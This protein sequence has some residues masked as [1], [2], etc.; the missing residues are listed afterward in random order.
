MKVKIGEKEW[1]R[2]KVKSQFKDELGCGD[3]ECI[4][5]VNLSCENCKFYDDIDV[6]VSELEIR[7]D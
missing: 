4:T 7:E 1:S 5:N 2:V 3:F 6:P